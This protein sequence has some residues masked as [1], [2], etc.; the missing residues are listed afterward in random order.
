[1]SVTE[2]DNSSQIVHSTGVGKRN[3]RG[4]WQKLAILHKLFTQQGL[5]KGISADSGRSWQFFTN[6]SINW[7][8]EK[9]ISAVCAHGSQARKNHPL[10]AAAAAMW[11]AS[12]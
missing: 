9:G 12:K 5:E 2:V 3:L 1:M 10:L 6:C 11:G 7:V 8:E 4:V